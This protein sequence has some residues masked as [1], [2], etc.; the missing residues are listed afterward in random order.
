MFLQGLSGVNVWAYL[1][2]SWMTIRKFYD[3][4]NKNVRFKTFSLHLKGLCK[5]QK[6]LSLSHVPTIV[7]RSKCTSLFGLIMSDNKK[8]L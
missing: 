7:V 8:V 2:S 3:I 4:Y 6:Y 1:A 5:K